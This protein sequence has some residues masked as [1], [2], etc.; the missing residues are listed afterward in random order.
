MKITNQFEFS[1]GK[2]YRILRRYCR[3]YQKYRCIHKN[4]FLGEEVIMVLFS[5]TSLTV[6]FNR[7]AKKAVGLRKK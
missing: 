2:H 7:Y 3:V 5:I 1:A 6:V 4:L